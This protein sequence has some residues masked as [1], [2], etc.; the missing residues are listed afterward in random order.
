MHTACAHAVRAGRALCAG[1]NAPNLLP[2][3]SLF[4]GFWRRPRSLPAFPAFA[5]F[6]SAR[7]DARVA[8]VLLYG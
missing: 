3:G 7:V 4:P 2:R 5:A 6:H 8:F 1:T